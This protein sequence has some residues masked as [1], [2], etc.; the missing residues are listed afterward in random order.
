MT[1]RQT[2]ELLP[3][4][5]GQFR[6]LARLIGLAALVGVVAGL[7]AVAFQ[8][9]SGAVVKGGLEFLAGYFPRGP[10]NEV[11]IIEIAHLNGVEEPQ[12]FVADN[13]SEGQVFMADKIRYKI[14]DEYE[15]EIADYR[16]VYKAVVG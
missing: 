6:L 3:A 8:V 15:V 13:P 4:K 12:M 14:R 2:E 10:I 1:Q 9:L 5:V 11:E 7:G 16:G